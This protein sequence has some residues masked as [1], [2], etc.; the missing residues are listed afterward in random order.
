V[1]EPTDAEAVRELRA[2]L[3][4]RT[5]PLTP[6][7]DLYEDIRRRH[8][9][10]RGTLIAGTAAVAAAAAVAVPALAL[11]GEPQ[12]AGPPAA[13]TAPAACSPEPGPAAPGLRSQGTVAGSLGG[14]PATVTAVLR[15]G[16]QR[17]RQ[18]TGSGT[19][20]DP[21][22]ATVR[23]VQRAADGTIVGLVDATGSDRRLGRQVV[24]VTGTR[25]DRLS[26][27]RL[28][29][30][31]G[32]LSMPKELVTV[33]RACGHPRVAVLVPPGTAAT[34]FEVT[35]VEADATVNRRTRPVPVR[36]D[37]V[38]VLDQPTAPTARLVLRPPVRSGAAGLEVGVGL[39]PAVPACVRVSPP[40]SGCTTFQQAVAAAPGDGDQRQ[41]VDLLRQPGSLPL[42]HVDL[43]VLWR[44]TTNGGT[45]T[46]AVTTL[47]SGA[48]YVWGGM[49]SK[50]VPGNAG[51]FGVLPA[52]GL[53]RTVLIYRSPEVLEG[54]QVA[55]N[56][57]A[58][59][60]PG[61]VQVRATVDGV[62]RTVTATDGIL[63]K[64]RT[65]TGIT[66]TRADGTRLRTVEV[67]ALPSPYL[68][69]IGS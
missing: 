24:A 29:D 69:P 32:L 27:E 52:G 59:L 51:F 54:S 49:T 1:T 34:L 2:T 11:G 47:P 5:G 18:A 45:V 15:V 13:T 20:L 61:T 63:F 3:A 14:D 44:G 19:P 42:T 16:W 58:I 62:Q 7:P 21:A 66:V 23:F 40:G 26:T 33:V 43:R 41:A 28:E 6:P 38:A 10:G 53:D 35:D 56:V 25:P 67:F 68:L 22:T 65:F 50:G 8:R 17:L 64:G 55:P 12:Q 9:R 31:N 39:L 46:A 37:G 30:E 57:V 4:D 36:P 48:Q 60:V